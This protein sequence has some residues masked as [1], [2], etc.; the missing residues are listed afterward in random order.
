MDWLDILELPNV[1]VVSVETSTDEIIIEVECV[2]G[3]VK[4]SVCGYECNSIH[5]IKVKKVKDLPILKKKCFIKFHHR[6]FYCSRCDKTFMERLSWVDQY[7]R[8]TL[9]YADWVAEAGKE[10]DVKKAACLLGVGYKV[11]ERI[12]YYRGKDLQLPEHDSFPER[13]GIDE[14]ANKKGKK[15]YCVAIAS[16][17]KLLHILP[18]R[19]EESLRA[20]FSR[21]KQTAREKVAV[22]SMDMW[23]TFINLVEEFFPNAAIVIDRFHVMGQMNKVVDKIRK[24]VQKQQSDEERKE[25]KGLRWVVLKN[26]EDISCEEQMLLKKAFSCSEKL[27]KV[28]LRKEEFRRIFEKNTSRKK[29]ER[30]LNEW[31]QRAVKIRHRQMTTFLK[32]VEKRKNYILNYFNHYDNNGFMEGIINKIKNIIRRHYGLAN[33]THLKHRIMLSFT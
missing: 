32:T 29:A 16:R 8:Y 2:N 33:F 21:I 30:Q 31:I 24:S 20:F 22:V 15:D 17:E 13:F 3:T 27:H 23:N 11:V 14:F 10:I 19:K 4:C 25:L 28:Y 12:V 26:N 1:K 9:R 6:R 5:S 7:E 18:S